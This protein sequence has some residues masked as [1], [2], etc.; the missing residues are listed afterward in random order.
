MRLG[1]NLLVFLLLLTFQPLWR[2][3]RSKPTHRSFDEL[4]EICPLLRTRLDR[5]HEKQKELDLRELDLVKAV[6]EAVEMRGRGRGDSISNE[7]L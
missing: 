1:R 4:Q 5:M 2:A 7:T 6:E 3:A